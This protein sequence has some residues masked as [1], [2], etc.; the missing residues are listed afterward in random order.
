MLFKTRL[1]SSSIRSLP[2][3]SHLLPEDGLLGDD[4]DE[5]RNQVQAEVL[6]AGELV[7]V[8]GY[9]RAD[10]LDDRVYGCVVRLPLGGLR[11]E[12]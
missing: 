4:L 3:N 7:V 1:L 8:P 6:R 2:I 9:E 5:G 10:A 12:R 11:R